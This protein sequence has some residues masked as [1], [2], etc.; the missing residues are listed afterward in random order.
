MNRFVRA[1][2]R[3]PIVGVVFEHSP[4]GDPRTWDLVA[5]AE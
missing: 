2:G 1:Q 5:S 3:P 4:G